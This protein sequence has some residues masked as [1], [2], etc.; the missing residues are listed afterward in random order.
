LILIPLC[1][2][3]ADNT[4]FRYPNLI[5]SN[6]FGSIYR[7][8]GTCGI[9]ALHASN[10]ETTDN[11]PISTR[12]TVELANEKVWS[13][14][15][16]LYEIGYSNLVDYMEEQRKFLLVMKCNQT[17]SKWLW[18]EAEWS[19]QLHHREI[20]TKFLLSFIDGASILQYQFPLRT[21][22]ESWCRKYPV[23]RMETSS[24]LTG[25]GFDPEIS[26]NPLSTFVIQP[27]KAVNGG[28]GFYATQA[29]VNGSTIALGA[30]V[31][32]IH[33][34]STA[35]QHIIDGYYR[36]EQANISDFWEVTYLGFIEGYGW[37]SQDYASYFVSFLYLRSGDLDS[38]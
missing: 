10:I 21:V 12:N 17:R 7:V 34:P 28:R 23:T 9:L 20:P 14:L 4:R 27:S 32:G 29:I 31:E 33:V 8:L 35:F 13:I 30:C 11:L 26:D 38:V 19:V 15:D 2:F 16:F 37:I 3:S 5:D 1:G 18:N 24:C 22:E 36:M 25:H 6:N